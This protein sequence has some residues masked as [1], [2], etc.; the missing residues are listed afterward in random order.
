MKKQS[1]YLISY[2]VA[3][4]FVPLIVNPITRK[5]FIFLFNTEIDSIQFTIYRLVLNMIVAIITFLIIH[6]F[7][8]STD[9]KVEETNEKSL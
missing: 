7:Q 9:N 2:F 3:G 1:K 5:S 6:R 4:F 8:K